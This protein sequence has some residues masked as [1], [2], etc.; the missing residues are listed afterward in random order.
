MISDPFVLHAVR[1]WLEPA[2][3]PYAERTLPLLADPE[4]AG[5]LAELCAD[6]HHARLH[7]TFYIKAEGEV[8]VAYVDKGRFWP[9]EVKWTGQVRPGDLKQ[10]R[11]YPN[12]GLLSR[13]AAPTLHGIRN[14]LLPLHLL[15]LGPSPDTTPE[16]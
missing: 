16:A 2:A 4:W 14:E 9:L 10:L 12:G 3:D 13:E 5:R 8:D 1:S 15:R 7:P 6:V 11:K